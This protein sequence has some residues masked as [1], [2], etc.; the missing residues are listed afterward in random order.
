MVALFITPAQPRVV[1]H[2]SVEARD[3]NRPAVLN[4]NVTISVHSVAVTVEQLAVVTAVDVI[5]ASETPHPTVGEQL[6]DE[7]VAVGWWSGPTGPK[8]TVT[9]SVQTEAVTV[10]HGGGEVLE[11]GLESGGVDCGAL[12]V[13][14]GGGGVDDA[15]ALGVE[16]GGSVDIVSGSMENPKSITPPLPS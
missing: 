13:E 7:T 3:E 11:G 15:G 6:R 2:I 10:E 1:E 4:S 9:N 16:L 5:V 8:S 14:L 12:G